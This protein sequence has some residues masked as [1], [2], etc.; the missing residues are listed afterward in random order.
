VNPVPV[1][2]YL[3]NLIEMVKNKRITGG[4]IPRLTWAFLTFVLLFA[5]LAKPAK[6][7]TGRIYGTSARVSE[8]S[9]KAIILHN[10]N[11]EV[12]ILGT[13]LKAD[14]PTGIIRFIPFPSEPSVK[15]APEKC[16]EAMS[17]LIMEHELQFLSQS[18]SGTTSGI[19]VELHFNQKL[20]SHDI[21]V[22][23]INDASK[24]REWVNGF[25]KQKGLPV[26]SEYPEIEGIVNDYVSRGIDWFVFDYV[27]ITSETRFI[28][29]LEY[30]FE[31][32]SLY[33][34]LKTSNTFGG[35]GGIDLL[36]IAPVTL[37]NPYLSYYNGCLG[38]R[39]LKATT[40]S[41]IG[42]GELSGIFSDPEA[43]FGQQKIFAQFLSYHGPYDFANDII[44]DFSNGKPY[45][46]WHEDEEPGFI[47]E[48]NG[49]FPSKSTFSF[50]PFTSA[51]KYFTVRIP[52]EWKVEESGIS[53]ENKQYELN[54]VAP[55]FKYPEDIDI[56][57][58]WTGDRIKTAERFLFDLT[59]PEYKP[60]YEESGP[61]TDITVGGKKAIQ[62]NMKS[63]RT[64]PAGMKG[65]IVDIVRKYVVVPETEGFFVL[66][67][68]APAKIT[69]GY[70]WIFDQVVQSFVSTIVQ[71]K[72]SKPAQEISGEEYKVYGDFFKT[73]FGKEK[74]YPE[75][76]D[77]I[78][79]AGSVFEITLTVKKSD[80]S[81]FREVMTAAGKDSAFL[82]SDF[83]RKNALEF[84]LKDKILARGI[85]ILSEEE[86][87]AV[88][89]KHG[90]QETPPA[91][92]SRLV[93]LSRVGFSKE[94]NFA[95]FYISNSGSPGTSYFVLM[96]KK[97]TGWVFVK[98]F[99]DRMVIF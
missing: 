93:Y 86:R 12:L 71:K 97:D 2:L 59:N 55:G 25:F 84:R 5:L 14:K 47:D 82:K 32:K 27:E 79:E 53:K 41:A 9:Q 10:F 62:L 16:F 42:K 15:L 94:K 28:E 33:Y 68:E 29:P 51:G 75:Y 18:K 65:D 6:C 56:A 24:F 21:A 20:G 72:D 74:E 11:E 1:L 8:E 60:A 77:N 87:N 35:E 90:L 69:R 54:L 17:T 45:A 67:Y 96:R 44:S 85:S 37:N 19:P 95:V 40:S 64:P 38:V 91:E 22:L 46:I 31:S 49:D 7:D 58:T 57:I 81:S 13:D 66:S 92:L 3:E 30:R 48:I 89:K 63:K 73:R 26:K 36:V 80:L 4:H 88:F 78:L 98:A 83:M 43:F 52:K 99:A 76:F 23:K 61:L 70:K 50:I 39:G 34:P